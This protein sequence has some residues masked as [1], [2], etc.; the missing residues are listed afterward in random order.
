M[1]GR[2]PKPTSMKVIQGTFRPDRAK[3]EPEYQKG[4]PP[5]PDHLSDKARSAWNHI[6][7]MLEKAGLLTHGDGFAL[8]GLCEAYADLRDARA[9]I[10]AR[11]GLT[12]VTESAG[13]EMVR[14]FPEI[15]M[16]SDADKR[17]RAWL[18]E[19]GLTPSSRARVGVPG[20]GKSKTGWED[21]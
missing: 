20:A 1:S 19:F 3:D 5:C 10:R 11:G 13:G 15:T 14:P 12:Y 17:Y 8:E 6:G 9:A 2:K 21:L 16:I 4:L 7:P 18:G